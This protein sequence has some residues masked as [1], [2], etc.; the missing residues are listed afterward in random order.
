MSQPV[1]RLGDLLKDR[2]LITDQ[3]IHYAL[4]EQRVTRQKLGEVLTGIGIV[5][6][7]DLIQALS[8][9]LGLAHIDLSREAPDLTLLRSF[10]RQTCLH[11]RMLP[12]R[13]EGDWVRVATSSLPGPDL[14]QACLRF[15]G[16]KPQVV[17]TEE[18]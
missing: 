15:C 2:G 9:Q 18:S 8:E 16:K 3:H 5:S 10:N 11:L 13:L 17:L 1:I 7:Y 12:L 6:E 4:Q 14:E